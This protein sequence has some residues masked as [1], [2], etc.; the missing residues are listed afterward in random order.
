VLGL[1]HLELDI[2]EGSTAALVFDELCRRQPRL[3]AMKPLLRCAVDQVYAD[4]DSV[5]HDGAEVAL[6][7]PTAGG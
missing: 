2:A 6:I 7:P 4:W 1:S 3:A 5:L